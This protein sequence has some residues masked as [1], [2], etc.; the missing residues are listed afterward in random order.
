MHNCWGRAVRA[1]FRPQVLV[2]SLEIR[3]RIYPFWH[4]SSVIHSI[5]HGLRSLI[6]P[7]RASHRRVAVEQN[8]ARF[9]FAVVEVRQ[10]L[11]HE[12]GTQL[13]REKLGE[14][15]WNKVYPERLEKLQPVGSAIC[16]VRHFHG[17]AG[18]HTASWTGRGGSSLEGRFRSR[19]P[20]DS[21]VHLAAQKVHQH[22][23][24]NRRE[25]GPYRP[26]DSRCGRG[27]PGEEEGE[28][29]PLVKV[30][31]VQEEEEQMA[32]RE[33]AIGWKTVEGARGSP[34]EQGQQ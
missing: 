3:Q 22:P 15:I 21:L 31:V 20:K 10:E 7:H 9:V 2:E 34:R 32:W 8:F 4:P 16:R 26:W 14:W 33:A 13:Q 30:L 1:E 28:F 12:I 25:R 18:P 27:R 6:V 23:D 11:Y 29:R 19:H 24:L 17:T 5:S